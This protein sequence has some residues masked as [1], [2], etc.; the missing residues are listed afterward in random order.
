ME[1]REMMCGV[2]ACRRRSTWG[3]VES[4]WACKGRWSSR[5]WRCL[6]LAYP[7]SQFISIS[8]TTA[9]L[10][11][12]AQN[13][14]HRICKGTLRV[15]SLRP[16][17]P[18]ALLATHK[19]ASQLYSSLFTERIHFDVFRV[20]YF[21]N[22]SNWKFIRRKFR[23]TPW[24]LSL[25]GNEYNFMTTFSFV[26]RGQYIPF[27]QKL[28]PSFFY[29]LQPQTFPTSNMSHFPSSNN[30]I[31]TCNFPTISLFYWATELLSIRWIDNFSSNKDFR[32]WYL[33]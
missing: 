33:G 29:P 26:R 9:P 19:V 18:Y 13:G 5:V 11:W 16:A 20:L 17:P 25:K 22:D 21:Q 2:P 24:G 8:W 7:H 1:F 3:C 14:W 28:A 30:F 6:Q 4:L 31:N 32:T 23:F 10:S 15:T 27:G 12:V